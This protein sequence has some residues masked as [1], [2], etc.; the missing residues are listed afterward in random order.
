MDTKESVQRLLDLLVNSP[1]TTPHE[2]DIARRHAAVPAVMDMGGALA[3]TADGDVLEILWD[4]PG[5]ATKVTDPRERSIAYYAVSQRYPELESISPKRPA[6][7]R[8]C[9][10]CGGTGR[11]DVPVHLQDSVRC[12]CG[13]L[14]WVP[15]EASQLPQVE[16]PR[17]LRPWWKFW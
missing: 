5:T 3:I 14:G 10:A 4:H 17:A 13:G 12:W 1:D 8:D 2:L 16:A 11:P 6:S 15:D 7:A 9:R